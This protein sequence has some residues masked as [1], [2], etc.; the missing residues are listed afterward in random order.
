MYTTGRLFEMQKV[1]AT[2][3]LCIEIRKEVHTN[4]ILPHSEQV[5]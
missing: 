5:C 1:A 2:V 3:S 4:R